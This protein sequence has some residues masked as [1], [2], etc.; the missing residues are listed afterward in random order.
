MATHHQI[1]IRRVGNE[2]MPPQPMPV[3]FVDDTVQYSS[4]DGA[5][6]IE[7]VP[8]HS[9][10]Q[11]TVIGSGQTVTVRN[12]GTFRCRCFITLNDGT[13]RVGWTGDDSP[14]GADHDIQR[15]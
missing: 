13:G 11:E 6:S 12:A 15:H 10:F 4:D 5:V 2:A 14:S 3:M 1:K 8:G 9:P 7:F